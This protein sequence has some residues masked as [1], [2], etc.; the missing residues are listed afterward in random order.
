[1]TQEEIEMA[2]KLWLEGKDTKQIAEHLFYHEN[3]I[4]KNIDKIKKAAK[5]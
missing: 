2:A 4:Y 5:Q 3:V 1:M